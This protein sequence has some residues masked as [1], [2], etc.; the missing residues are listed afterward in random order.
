MA[1]ETSIKESQYNQDDLPEL[2]K[3]YYKR[4]FPYKLYYQ[5]LSYGEGEI[6]SEIFIAIKTLIFTYIN[7]SSN[8]A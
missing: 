8:R 2:L 5:W 6:C 7:P 1:D 3:Q 4:I